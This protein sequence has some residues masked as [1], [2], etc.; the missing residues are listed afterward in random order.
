MSLMACSA[1]QRRSRRKVPSEARFGELTV[2]LGLESPI[3][4]RR[5]VPTRSVARLLSTR[6]IVTRP[7]PVS[8]TTLQDKTRIPNRYRGRRKVRAGPL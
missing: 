1:P 3:W 4:K 7:R 5:R 2:Y 6:S 8:P